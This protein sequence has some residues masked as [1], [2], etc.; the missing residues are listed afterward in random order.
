MKAR[1]LSLG[2]ALALS[3]MAIVGAGPAQAVSCSSNFCSARQQS[4]L[5]GCPCAE[6]YCNPV[7][8]WSDCVCPIFCPDES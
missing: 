3:V 4:C 7:S 8:C 1:I 2:C 5:S 6:F